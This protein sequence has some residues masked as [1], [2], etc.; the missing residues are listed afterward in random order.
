MIKFGTSGWRGIIAEEFTYRNVA[1]VTQAI[2]NLIKE[3]YTNASVIIGYDTRFMSEDFA[4]TAAEILAG[5]GIKA[6]L[7]KKD[8]PTP[9]IAY[10]VVHSGLSGGI[11]FTASHNPYKYNGLKYSL[12]WGGHALSETTKKIEKYCVS[13]QS[14]DIKS[15]PLKSGIKSKLIELHNPQAD[16]IKRI[17]ELVNFKALKKSDIRVAVDVMHGTGS[18]YLNV[19][20][21]SAGINHTTI[22]KDRDTMFGGGAPEPVE[23]N[24]SEL[25]NMV[26]KE[27]YRLGLSTDVDADRFGIIDSDGTF[28]TPNQVIPILLYHLNRTRGW[29]GIAV[30]SVMTSHLLDKFAAKIGV[31]VVETP[32]GFKY[33]GEVMMNN[34]DK[35]LIGG[36]ESGGL[37]IRGH[38]PEKDGILA[39]LLMTEAVAMSKKSV[40][41]LLKDIKKLTGETLTSRLN[42]CLPSET[43]E[44]FRNILETKPPESIAGMKVQKNITVDGHKFILEDS[45]WIGFRV[46]GT[47]PLVRIYAESDSQTKLNKL[48]KIGKDFVYGK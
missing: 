27:S 23:K 19:L 10:S 45:T 44:I 7:C 4:K 48:L 30:R 22:N 12:A 29:T 5:N 3:E 42:F 18:D 47:E 20:L 21:D 2:A 43:M 31:E 41:G 46:S 40:A 9:V 32:V 34:P 25:L 38:V 6:L 1:V 16:Y 28:I 8:T 39:C 13:I 11:N 35:F 15:V 33:I 26:K 37:T 14:K 24:L 36:E 17:K